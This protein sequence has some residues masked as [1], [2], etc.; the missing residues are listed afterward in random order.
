M[1]YFYKQFGTFVLSGP[2]NPCADEMWHWL[3]ETWAECASCMI[4]CVFWLN[5]RAACMLLRLYSLV[6]AESVSCDDLRVLVECASCAYAAESDWPRT[7]TYYIF[8]AVMSA[9]K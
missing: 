7:G 3:A 4:F 1:G 5:A 8:S 6:P 9:Q 2:G